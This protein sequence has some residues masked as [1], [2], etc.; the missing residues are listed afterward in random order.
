MGVPAL[1]IDGW[2]SPPRYEPLKRHLVWGLN[3]HDSDGKVVNFF[4]RFLGR[5]GFLSINLIDDSSKIEASK[6]QALSVLTAIHYAPGARYEDHASGDKDS[7]LGLKSLVLAGTGVVIAKKTGILIAIL[8]ALKKGVIVIVAA[9]GAFF[10]R[11]FGRRKRDAD[12][13][14]AT[15]EEP[16][17]PP[18]PSPPHDDL[19]PPPSD[20]GPPP[21]D[22]PR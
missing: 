14:L 2:S 6:A 9:I 10:K 7:G 5:N 22:P 19:G 15:S 21:S 12:A 1:F 16:V 17:P 11:L 13:V 18:E 3:G 8:L 20:P 4:T